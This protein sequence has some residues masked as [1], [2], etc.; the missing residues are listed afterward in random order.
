VTPNQAATACHKNL[1]RHPMT[2]MLDTRYA[3]CHGAWANC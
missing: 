3:M 1:A 2:S